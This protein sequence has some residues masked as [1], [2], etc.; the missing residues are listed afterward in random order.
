MLPD[1]KDTK[2]IAL[3]VVQSWWDGHWERRYV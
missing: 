3:E 1:V 2:D